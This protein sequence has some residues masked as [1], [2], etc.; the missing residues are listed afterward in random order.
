MFARRVYPHV[1]STLPSSNLISVC[2]RTFAA[3][4]AARSPVRAP[5]LA[6]ITPNDAA[7]FSEKQ[8]EFRES[9]VAAQKQ[10]E[11]EEST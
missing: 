5:V 8:K 1:R 11:Q 7:S 3:A 6:D 2:S 4:T 10:K 9:L